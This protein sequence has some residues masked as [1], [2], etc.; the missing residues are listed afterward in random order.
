VT[1]I[2]SSL[3]LYKCIICSKLHP[4]KKEH[5]NLKFYENVIREIYVLPNSE[6]G[7]D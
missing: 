5:L 7:C 4:K 2:H 6:N 3:E 1:R